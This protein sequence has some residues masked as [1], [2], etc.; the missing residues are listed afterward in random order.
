[1]LFETDFFLKVYFLGEECG[2]I[3][4]KIVANSLRYTR[5]FPVGKALL[6]VLKTQQRCLVDNSRQHADRQEKKAINRTKF[7]EF[8]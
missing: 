4:E 3:S 5:R 6:F 8:L 7:F 2:R 1:M